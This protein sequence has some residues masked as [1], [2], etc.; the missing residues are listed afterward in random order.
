LYYPSITTG[1]QAGTPNPLAKVRVFLEVQRPSGVPKK[2]W[3]IPVEEMDIFTGEHVRSRL[4]KFK[5]L[6]DSDKV[7]LAHIRPEDGGRSV[8]G[9]GVE[10]TFIMPG[11]SPE[12]PDWEAM[13]QGLVDFYS[14]YPTALDLKLRATLEVE[15]EE[16]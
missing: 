8:Q 1:S 9:V 10:T 3:S 15:D 2:C 12:Q 14:K 11:D 13:L 5:L 7:L 16:V 4:Q 6:K